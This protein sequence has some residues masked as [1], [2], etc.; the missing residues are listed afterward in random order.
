IFAV[1]FDSSGNVLWAQ[2]AG[3]NQTDYGFGNC[4]DNDGN[5]YVTGDF[6]ST[7]ITFGNTI[8]TNNGS[9]WD[10]FV[11]KYDANGNVL[12]AKSA[13]GTQ[14]EGG[15]KVALAENGN[16]IV[17]GKLS[18]SSVVIGDTVLSSRGSSDI[19]L[20]KYDTN[21]N[22]LWARNEG[23]NSHEQIADVKETSGKYILMGSFFSP[24]ISFDNIVLS[25][26]GGYD[27][28]ITTFDTYGNFQNA[29]SVGGALRD[30][31]G[32]I[33]DAIGMVY[34]SGSFQSPTIHFGSMTI[35]HSDTLNPNPYTDLFLA[36]HSPF[37]EVK[38]DD[39]SQFDF[40]LAQNY[41]N[42]F[43]PQTAISFS[44]L[45]VG[46]VTL[47]VYDVL[48]REVATLLNNETMQAGR[49]EIQFDG[50]KFPSGVYFYRLSVDGIDEMHTGENSVVVRKMLLM[51]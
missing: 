14:S 6:R 34:I 46:N 43:N 36:K 25:N 5:I 23:G 15:H 21:G 4:I 10:L 33:T 18:S 30:E 9:W 13:G 31:G 45:A 7:T 28:F 12:W 41:P 24:T 35:T 27:M 44:L 20:V 22:V 39:N 8:L 2:S 29:I 50:S 47:K 38:E 49:H 16:I 3:G 1:K 11:V 17:A 40:S 42:P 51:K 26:A 32:G 48:G 37:T 19:L